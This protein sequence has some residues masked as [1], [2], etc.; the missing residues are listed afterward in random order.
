VKNS[1]PS[2]LVSAAAK[3]ADARAA[4]A[5]VDVVF[6]RGPAPKILGSN[7]PDDIAN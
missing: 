7:E 5:L 1:T 4:F 3:A 6:P 2:S